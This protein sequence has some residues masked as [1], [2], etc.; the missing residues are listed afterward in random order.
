MMFV[1]IAPPLGCVGI[2][3]VTREDASRPFGPTG[4]LQF[5]KEQLL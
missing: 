5:R 3:S 4:I 1:S 2:T